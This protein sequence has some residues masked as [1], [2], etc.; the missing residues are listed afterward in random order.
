MPVGKNREKKY[1]TIVA[2]S[3]SLLLCKHTMTLIEKKLF[4]TALVTLKNDYESPGGV[5]QIP[6]GRQVEVTIPAKVIKEKLGLTSTNIYTKLYGIADNFSK[7]R[8]A[9]KKDPESND[10]SDGAF[11]FMAPFPYC[12]YENGLFTMRF[13]SGLNKEIANLDRGN[14]ALSDTAYTSKFTKK[15]ASDL[16]DIICWFRWRGGF[17]V[18]IEELRVLLGLDMEVKDDKGEIKTVK[19]YSTF[20]RLNS[21]I[22]KPG[23]DEINELTDI[24]VTVEPIKRRNQVTHL[25]FDIVKKT[26]EQVVGA[27]DAQEVILSQPEE[28]DESFSS[29]ARI[30]K[31]I[32]TDDNI[33]ENDVLLFLMAANGDQELV[34][35]KWKMYQKKT[36]ANTIENPVGWIITAIKKNYQ[37]SYED[38]EVKGI[39]DAVQSDDNEA[40][41]DD[42]AD[43]LYR[44]PFKMKDIRA[45]ARQ[46]GYDI[47]RVN[48][49]YTVL[50]AQKN[51]ADPVAFMIAAIK[52]EYEPSTPRA[53]SGARN[54]FNFFEQRKYD[55]ADYDDLELRKI[56]KL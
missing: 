7:I 54:S 1:D 30:L 55:A 13:E 49:A 35:E 45:I 6:E 23:I 43:L 47:S 51:V 32:I 9:L 34:V 25:R 40:A 28:V 19:K 46:A 21:D 41:I 20:K 48:R 12:K 42:I 14:Y 56:G 5:L 10:V 22:I 15:A 50:R 18:S 53:T 8:F 31:M 11:E 29:S 36:M 16:Y 39:V 4:D 27:G 3:P 44:E 17:T 37:D 38:V 2:K 33:T 24:I 26:A 52:G